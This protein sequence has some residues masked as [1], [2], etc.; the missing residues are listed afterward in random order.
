MVIG[1]AFLSVG[2]L[3]FVFVIFFVLFFC[4]CCCFFFNLQYVTA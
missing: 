1:I 4:F 2:L 3:V